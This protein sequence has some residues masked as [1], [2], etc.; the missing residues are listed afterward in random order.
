MDEDAYPVDAELT[1]AVGTRVIA[2]KNSKKLGYKNGSLG[3]VI[4][5]LK[6]S[7]IVKF[8]QL[9]DK[10]EVKAVWWEEVRHSDRNGK[11]TKETARRFKQL[12]LQLG[13][14]ITIHK[15]QGM[16]LDN[17]VI[18]L[19]TGAFAKGQLY[20]ALS[21]ARTIGGVWLTQEIEMSDV[22]VSKKHRKRLKR[23][24]RV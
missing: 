7:V 19:G 5:C 15:S 20:V 8:D 11:L 12:P 4:K 3:T 2:V 14:A 24:K 9:A 23:L 16:S 22:I 1:L 10:V 13:Y 21:R 6:Y 18:D 17:V